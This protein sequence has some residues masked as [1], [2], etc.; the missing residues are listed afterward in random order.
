[1]ILNA[2]RASLRHA[3]TPIEAPIN[4]PGYGARLKHT[5]QPTV[6]IANDQM[7]TFLKEMKSVKLRRV[8]DA[9]F[10][11][12][13]VLD[14]RPAQND[15]PSLRRRA[16]VA[17]IRNQA[18]GSELSRRRSTTDLANATIDH[19]PPARYRDKGKGRAVEPAN[20]T[21]DHVPAPRPRHVASTTV[22]RPQPAP[23]VT[24][25]SRPTVNAQPPQPQAGPSNISKPASQKPTSRPLQPVPVP[26]GESSVLTKPAAVA[27]TQQKKALDYG[28]LTVDHVA[29][30]RR[31]PAVGVDRANVTMD[32][33]A[34]GEKR[35]RTADDS[36]TSRGMSLSL[37]CQGKANAFCRGW[38]TT[39]SI[40]HPARCEARVEG[41]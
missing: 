41:C 1:M 37:L 4:G 5:G 33:P 30:P 28:N 12:N 11:N 19:L 21:I 24:R 29:L 39:S 34:V 8:G 14:A 35:K 9:S 17:D 32:Q 26:P 38:S 6:K 13:S 20:I 36:M 10:A 7:A 40:C 3:G 16:T 22:P 31:R 15:E 25:T 27:R 23:P 18:N 2:V